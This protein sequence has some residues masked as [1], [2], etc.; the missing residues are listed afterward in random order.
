M[1]PLILLAPLLAAI[2]LSPFVKPSLVKLIAIAASLIS[3]VLYL[4]V[5]SGAATIAWFSLGGYAFTISTMVNPIN[6][7]L[8]L[9]VLSIAPLIL[10]YSAGFMDVQ[11]EQ[12]RFYIEMLGFEAAMLTFSMAGSF[13]LLFIAWEYLSL[14]SYLLIGFWHQREKATAATAMTFTKD[15]LTKDDSTIAASRGASK[16]NGSM[17]PLEL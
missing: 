17:L 7:L 13:I 9:A 16:I 15:G 12:K 3:L 10:L 11:S 4:L 5:S 6:R 8:M 14:T 2:A 1:L